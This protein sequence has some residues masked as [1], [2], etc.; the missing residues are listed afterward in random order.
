MEINSK[1]SWLSELCLES[2]SNIIQSIPFQYFM[3]NIS[4]LIAPLFTS[5]LSTYKPAVL[6]LAISIEN[7]CKK[8]KK[9]IPDDLINIQNG[10]MK[11][12]VKLMPILIDTYR[13][14]PNLHSVWNNIIDY[15]SLGNI[16]ELI[17]LWK[18]ASKILYT[19][20]SNDK[21]KLALLLFR[22]ILPKIPT[23]NLKDYIVPEF[24]LFI[25]TQ[26]N[27]IK[28]NLHKPTM[29]LIHDLVLV[30]NLYF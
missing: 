10:V 3:K 24:F 13:F 4:P 15:Y 18:Q 7:Y 20:Q 17:P 19:S 28:H 26:I 1:K 22:V 30:Y 21:K 11:N 2:I 5:D 14:L 25:S 27:H 8:C 29:D 9:P 12:I 23:K 6:S 16:N